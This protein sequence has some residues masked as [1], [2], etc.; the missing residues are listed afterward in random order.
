[1]GKTSIAKTVAELIKKDTILRIGK[2]STNIKEIGPKEIQKRKKLPKKIGKIK[3]GHLNK[4]KGMEVKEL[5]IGNLVKR[6]GCIFQ[7]WS[8]K[9]NELE[10]DSK[11]LDRHVNYETYDNIE[12]IELTEELLKMFG[13]QGND[14]DMWIVMPTGDGV[15]LH[16][17]CI[18]EGVFLNALL[19]KGR[20]DKGIPGKDYT[21]IYLRQCKYVHQLQNLFYSLTG[22]ELKLIK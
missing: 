3:T 1:M 9:K 18:K 7:I 17:D 20:T 14:M 4:T 15:E 2:G 22:Y 11:E 21:Y 5:R 8:L 16:M 10:L 19:T 13:F 12:P 6:S